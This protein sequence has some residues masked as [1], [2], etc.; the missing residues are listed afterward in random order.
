MKDF[1]LKNPEI[2][3]GILKA[4]NFNEKKLN[5]IKKLMDSKIPEFSM[6]S[7][8]PNGIILNSTLP[9]EMKDFYFFKKY[10]NGLDIFKEEEYRCLGGPKS[11]D[12]YRIIL[13]LDKPSELKIFFYNPSQKK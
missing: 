13:N 2:M 3:E 9:E 7:T 8:R 11:W 1:I 5:L 12:Q 6:A 10:I 4:W